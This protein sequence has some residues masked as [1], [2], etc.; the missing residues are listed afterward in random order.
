M[1]P[2]GIR[3][4]EKIP[5]RAWSR[6]SDHLHAHLIQKCHLQ[7]VLTHF[8]LLFVNKTANCATDVTVAAC[9]RAPVDPPFSPHSDKFNFTPND[10]SRLKPTLCIH[11]WDWRLLISHF[12]I[13]FEENVRECRCLRSLGSN[14]SHLCNK[15]RLSFNLRVLGR[16]NVCDTLRLYL[17]R[18]S[19][20]GVVSHGCP[21]PVLHINSAPVRHP[22]QSNQHVS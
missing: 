4:S 7:R 2:A 13:A 14:G 20:S 16:I 22:Q 18:C 1:F 8:A 19:R 21:C 10:L 9:I 12:G 11:F 15:R 6:Q 3:Y 17:V 5:P